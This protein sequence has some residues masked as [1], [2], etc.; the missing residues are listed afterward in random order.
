MD[1][2]QRALRKLVEAGA[3]LRDPESVKESLAK[4]PLSAQWKNQ[5]IATYAAF[6]KMHRGSWKPPAYEVTRKLPFIP[7]EEEID[8]LIA[9]CGRKTATLLQL[10]KETGMRV[11]EALRSRWINVDLER[12]LIILNEPEKDGEPRSLR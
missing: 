8:A 6:L 12:R 7:T 11:G 9:G 5:M 1:I 4:M 2:Y 10:L 3:D